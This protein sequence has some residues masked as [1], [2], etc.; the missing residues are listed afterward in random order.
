MT[1]TGQTGA[2]K[3]RLTQRFF[4]N[5]QAVLGRSARI[6]SSGSRGLYLLI[7]VQ[8]LPAPFTN[9]VQ[10]YQIKVLSYCFYSSS[11]ILMA[12]KTDAETG[13]N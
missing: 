13:K 6:D 1:S 2:F 8:V 11:W 7:S 10:I 4:E 5:R 9:S 12:G 3:T